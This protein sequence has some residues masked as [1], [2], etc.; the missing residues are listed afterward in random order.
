MAATDMQLAGLER[1]CRV[2]VTDPDEL[3]AKGRTRTP[4]HAERMAQLRAA[5]PEGGYVVDSIRGGTV[6]LSRDDSEPF[7]LYAG[8]L[9]RTFEDARRARQERAQRLADAFPGEYDLS[10]TD[11]LERFC[12]V[13]ENAEDRGRFW[14]HFADTFEDVADTLGGEVLEG[15]SPLQVYDLDAAQA[16][17]LHI[18]SP[19][20][21][22]SE[23]QGL[24]DNALETPAEVNVCDGCGMRW[25]DSVL[26]PL[27]D[28]AER[29]A[30]GEPMP[31]GECPSCGAVC[32]PAGD[33]ERVQ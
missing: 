19:V 12:G 8:D 21:T 17:E 11:T 5:Q 6:T 18:A 30:P 20:V 3:N 14:L 23:D 26:V 22:R 10:P 27:R 15:W 1:G 4:E 32:H 9:T 16:I 13:Q 25:P 28:V 33:A 24:M 2:E 31:S 29:V 7:T